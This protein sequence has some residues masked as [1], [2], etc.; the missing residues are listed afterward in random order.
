MKFCFGWLASLISGLL[1]NLPGRGLY[2]F[3]DLLGLIWFDL[4]RI[5]RQ[6]VDENIQKVFPQMDRK[7][8]IRLARKSLRNMGRTVAEY[9]YLPVLDQDFVSKKVRLHNPENLKKVMDRKKGAF[10]LTL[11]L[12]NGDL[13]ICSMAAMGYPVALLTKDFKLKWLTEL[14]FGVRERSGLKLIPAR[15]SSYAVLKSLKANQVIG[16]PLDQFMGPPIG[17]KTKFFGHETGTA[18]GMAVMAERSGAGVVPTYTYRDEDGVTHIHFDPE[19]PFE[20]GED[21]DQA[22]VNMTQKYND[23]IEKYILKRPDQWMWVHK[24]WKR[25]VVT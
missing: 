25:F 19:I 3:G 10:L 16:F 17:A 13:A 12:G 8:R 9:T 5:R 11:H 2:Y 23:Q 14:W 15:N 4:L 18:L 22:L 24:R 21:R 7:S 20:K 1:R 6:V